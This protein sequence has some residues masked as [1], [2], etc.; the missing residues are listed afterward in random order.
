[1]SETAS[2]TNLSPTSRPSKRPCFTAFDVSKSWNKFNSCTYLI[3]QPDPSTTKNKTFFSF[4]KKKTKPFICYSVKYVLHKLT[5]QKWT[6]WAIIFLLPKCKEINLLFSFFYFQHGRTFKFSWFKPST[7]SLNWSF[8]VI[9]PRAF[10]YMEGTHEYTPLGQ[11]CFS[12]QVLPK[13]SQLYPNY[14]KDVLS[15]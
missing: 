7:T 11:P 1:M 5:L 2:P 12:K 10:F 13:F 8:K 14:L 4:P 9:D 6:T 15:L 3:N